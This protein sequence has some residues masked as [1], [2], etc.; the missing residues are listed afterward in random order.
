MHKSAPSE[1]AAGFSPC[2]PGQVQDPRAK[3]FSVIWPNCVFHGR[4]D[5][6]IPR[7]RPY[8][9]SGENA[10]IT[11]V[12]RR[13]RHFLRLSSLTDAGAGCGPRTERDPSSL[14]TV[15]QRSGSRQACE[16]GELVQSTGDTQ[17]LGLHS[18]PRPERG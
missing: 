10:G 5:K 6:V 14:G 12:L 4:K 15:G 8:G 9:R 11:A 18:R 3:A 7:V 17:G 16:S 13:A 1:F 2:S